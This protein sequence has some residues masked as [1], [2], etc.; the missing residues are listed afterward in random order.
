MEKGIKWIYFGG[1]YIILGFSGIITTYNIILYIGYNGLGNTFNYVTPQR[2]TS[3]ATQVD[4]I[5]KETVVTYSY[6]V[7]NKEYTAKQIMHWKGLKNYDHS[8]DSIYY[9]KQFPCLSYIKSKEFKQGSPIVGMV[10]G[11]LF[12]LIFFLI[13]R[14][15]D[16][17]K[18]IGVYARGEYKPSNKK[19]IGKKVRFFYS[20]ALKV[21][22]VFFGI[23]I[24][25][26]FFMYMIYNGVGDVFT[27][28]CTAKV[29]DAI[30]EDSIESFKQLDYWYVVNGKEYHSQRIMSYSEKDIDDIIKSEVYYNNFFPSINYVG[31]IETIQQKKLTQMLLWWV[32]FMIV[33]VLYS[34]QNMDKWIEKLKARKARNE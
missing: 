29:K 33:L 4:T 25:Y 3:T 19:S 32:G 22:L 6:W 28:E 11:G 1:L 10:L 7:S 13:Y 31:K 24:A 30:T 16:H 27:Y 23:N 12:F 5:Q 9:N 18:W 34:F 14:Y 2:Y 21:T 20:L 26:N 15:A 8:T 17:D